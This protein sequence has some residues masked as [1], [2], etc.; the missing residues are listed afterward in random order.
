MYSWI[1]RKRGR[2][3][4]RAGVSPVRAAQKN[5]WQVLGQRPS[6][7]ALGWRY[8]ENLTRTPWSVKHYPRDGT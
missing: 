8:E 4:V 2:Y 3:A 6:R 1:A 5:V 7:L